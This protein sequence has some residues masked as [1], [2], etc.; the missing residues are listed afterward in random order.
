MEPQNT[1]AVE[2]RLKL[3][4][5]AALWIF[6]FAALILFRSAILPFAGSALIAYVVAPA[7]DR[8]A[9]IRVGKRTVPRWVAILI[10]YAGFFLLVYVVLTALVP[11]IY[12]ELARIARETLDFTN[13][14]SPDRIQELAQR[15]ESWLSDHGVPLALSSRSLEGGE[16]DGETIPPAGQPNSPWSMAL[17]LNQVIRDMTIK[18]S[19]AAKENLAN[20][21]SISRSII[22][23]IIASIFTLFFMLMVAAFFSVD[24]TQI[25]AYC[26]TLIPSEYT[27]SA[28][29]LIG[30]IDRALAGVV[31]GQLTI[32]LVNGTLTFIGLMI[33]GVKFAFVL[34]T[35]ALLF[36][37]IPIFGTIISSVPIVLI[38]LSQSWK[39]GLAML[40]WIIGIHALE[41]YF[42][43]PKILGSAA[44]IH[45]VVVAFALIAGE[46]TYG[47][48]GALFA[49]PLAAIAVACFDFARVKA[50]EYQGRT[51]ASSRPEP[52]R[53]DQ[54]AAPD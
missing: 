19:G 16:I 6:A 25:K 45:P 17:D 24:A 39:K 21:L 30:R 40:L 54:R 46:R 23:G 36:S 4:T 15:A 31:R 48:V 5:F 33:F 29:E 14:L 47:L 26:R 12:R 41:A 50:L 7:V 53:P 22:G 10:I 35:V 18:F 37:L 52:R 42:L 44:R 13:S 20:I 34:A 2:R 9:Q 28:R 8:I 1:S 43:N 27:Q 3:R 49:V 11:Q 32:C 38:A 51:A